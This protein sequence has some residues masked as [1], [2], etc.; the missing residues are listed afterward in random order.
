MYYDNTIL[1]LSHPVVLDQKKLQDFF[2]F[3]FTR[4]WR[5]M[6]VA[7]MSLLMRSSCFTSENTKG[8]REGWSFGAK[9]LLYQ[10]RQY[11]VYQKTK[12]L[13]FFFLIQE[14]GL[15]PCQ[16]CLNTAVHHWIGWNTKQRQ[17]E[18]TWSC[19]RT[20]PI[21]SWLII[22]PTVWTTNHRLP[23]HHC[24]H[25]HWDTCYQSSL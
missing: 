4:H 20:A 25:T 9:V 17:R 21:I 13:V 14:T 15:P 22:K 10:N 24:Y 11:K 7:F 2:I 23:T 19:N 18:L 8:G 5:L 6:K 3:F 1:M 12:S 16:C